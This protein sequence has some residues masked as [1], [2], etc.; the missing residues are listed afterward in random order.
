MG[1]GGV[2]VCATAKILKDLGHSVRGADSGARPPTTD[3]LQRWGIPFFREYSP[4]NIPSDVDLVVIGR[5]T[6]LSPETNKEVMRAQEM[7][8]PIVS[9][10]DILNELTRHT[11]NL[12]CAGSYG[13]STCSALA[14]FCL[15]RAE[16]DPSFFLG[17]FPYNFEE[18]SRI[19][20]GSLFVL[21]GDEYPTSHT[22]PTSK[23]LHYN[24]SDVLVTAMAHDHL[25]VFKSQEDFNKPFFDLVNML[26]SDAHIA[27]NIDNEESR[28][29]A[30]T[31]ANRCVTY[32]L[33]HPARWTAH[34]IAH[35][36]SGTVFSLQ[37]GGKQVGQI[38][39]T[40]FGK[41]NV[42][43]I[44]GVASLLLEKEFV[45]IPQFISAVADFRGVQRR[46]DTLTQS[47]YI[48]LYEGF[49]SSFEKARAAIE[50]VLTRK[51]TRLI[52]LFE[53]HAISWKLPAYRDRYRTLFKGANKVYFYTAPLEKEVENTLRIT[54]ILP[55]IDEETIAIRT[56][57]EGCL[58]LEK[59]VQ[60]GDVVLA[61]SSG[62]FDG[63]T[64]KIAQWL[65]NNRV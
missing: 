8:V 24:P 17:A 50:A 19:G 39:T 40:L 48:P 2:G 62:N 6:N 4:E 16:K 44:V 1:I 38:K 54:D 7:G 11:R 10:P 31:L 52:V 36:K 15:T 5:T 59:E 33:E 34:D 22:D 37:C 51:Y 41:H 47:S 21:E 43:N 13:K 65:D 12:I 29:F 23:F 56:P 57:E 49:G 27:I 53:P 28:A 63:M 3:Y 25:N 45:S 58:A 55:L 46:L 32:A 61:L 30:E 35:E 26:P 18:S 14:A 20:N 64:V 9:F 60:E 42:E